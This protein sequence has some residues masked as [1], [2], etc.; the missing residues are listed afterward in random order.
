MLQTLCYM[1]QTPCHMVQT[2]A[3]RESPAFSLGV[4]PIVLL[5][6]PDQTQNTNAMCMYAQHVA[7]HCQKWILHL[8]KD[9]AGISH[10][11]IYS[12]QMLRLSATIPSW[13]QFKILECVGII[14]KTRCMVKSVSRGGLLISN[15]LRQAHYLCHGARHQRQ[16]VTAW[17]L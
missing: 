1:V 8:L 5:G 16:F 4:W 7:M 9:I 6:P 2:Q 3:P 12:L 13:L 17:Y 14:G 11:Q 15:S 10:F